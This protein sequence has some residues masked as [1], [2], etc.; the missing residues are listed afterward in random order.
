M[1][2]P[3]GNKHTMRRGQKQVSSSRLNVSITAAE[4][5]RYNALAKRR[6]VTLSDLVRSLLDAECEKG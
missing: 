6:K 4:Q 5:R 1:P 2:A 3:K